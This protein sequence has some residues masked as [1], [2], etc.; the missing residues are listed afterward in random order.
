MNA[1]VLAFPRPK[2]AR[3]ETVSNLATRVLPK[4]LGVLQSSPIPAGGRPCIILDNGGFRF[5]AEYCNPEPSTHF[6][7][8]SVRS[9]DTILLEA[10]IYNWPQGGAS[11]VMFNGRVWLRKFDFKGRADWLPRI[12]AI[13][14]NDCSPEAFYAWLTTSAQA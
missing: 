5:L 3:R 13:E 9:E 8:V 1:E 12:A 11:G 6:A 10:Y 4:M 14:A 2:K 7:E